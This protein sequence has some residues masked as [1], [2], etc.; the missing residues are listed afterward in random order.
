MI[1]D[2]GVDFLYYGF[3]VFW[4]AFILWAIWIVWYIRHKENKAIREGRDRDAYYDFNGVKVRKSD[5]DASMLGAAVMISNA[6]K[7]FK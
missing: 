6:L 1:A 4:G 5:Y 2:I 7:K 3:F